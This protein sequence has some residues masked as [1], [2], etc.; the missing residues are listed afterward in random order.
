MYSCNSLC[1]YVCYLILRSIAKII[2]V[3]NKK[4]SVKHSR[5]DTDEENL[6]YSDKPI[7]LK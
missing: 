6:K 7:I 5:N 2:S 3:I 1:V 4:L